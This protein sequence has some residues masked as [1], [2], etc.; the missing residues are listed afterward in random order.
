M[1]FFVILPSLNPGGSNAFG[2][3]RY[4]GESGFA[5]VRTLLGD[6]SIVLDRAFG[7]EGRAYLRG[8]FLPFGGTSLLA[9]DVLIG[10][11]SELALNLLS[12][13]APQRSIEFQY[14]SVTVAVAALAA[15]VGTA[16]IAGWVARRAHVRPAA[17]ATAVSAG[18]LIASLGLQ[19][20]EHGAPRALAS[21]AA[22]SYAYGSERARVGR[23]I[24]RNL[25]PDV[26]ISAQG[27]VAS[28]VSERPVVYV[29]PTVREAEW[30]VL[31]TAGN[32]F[33]VDIQRLPGL[34][35]EESY[36]EYAR[37]LVDDEG[38]RVET[39]RAGWIVLH[40]VRGA[41]SARPTVNPPTSATRAAPRVAPPPPS[42]P[43]AP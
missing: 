5:V 33:P 9:P 8:I 36:R 29:F 37:R 42:A 34:D 4:L 18:A 32:H 39:E 3:Y 31:D 15:V 12:S 24:V 28:H 19:I 13:F 14:A 7:P 41:D 1:C 21:D 6:P 27:S 20:E 16:R 11:A 25:P 40:R 43:V 2:R 35:A 30:V 17:V 23:A 22:G 38:F 26:P 10:A